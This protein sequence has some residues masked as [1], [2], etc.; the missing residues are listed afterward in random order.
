MD[1]PESAVLELTNAPHLEF[2]WLPECVV[3]V[4]VGEALAAMPCLRDLKL[5]GWPSEID[6]E[7]VF[8]L[9][10]S[11]TLAKL[12]I[13]VYAV[14]ELAPGGSHGVQLLLAAWTMLKNAMKREAP[15]L[16]IEFVLMALSDATRW[17]THV[18]P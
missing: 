1:L 7:G 11:K 5:S 9:T 15:N 17:E 2:L 10:R 3:T 6:P 14:E 8:A 4:R 16:S 13:S 12:E 18:V